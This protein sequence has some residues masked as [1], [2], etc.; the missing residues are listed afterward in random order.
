M[1][2]A[3]KLRRFAVLALV[4]GLVAQAVVTPAVATSTTGASSPDCDTS[5]GDLLLDLLGSGYSGSLNYYDDTECITEDQQQNISHADWYENAHLSQDNIDAF[6]TSETNFVEF[7]RSHVRTKVKA[8]LVE[9]IKNNESLATAKDEINQ[10]IDEF[11]V[12]AQERVIKNHNTTVLN[13]YYITNASDSTS[14]EDDSSDVHYYRDLGRVNSSYVKDEPG[15]GQYEVGSGG[16]FEVGQ[17]FQDLTL[18]TDEVT[19]VDGTTRNVTNLTADYDGNTAKVAFNPW[20]TSDFQGESDA[21]FVLDPGLDT[22]PSN[23]SE[24]NSSY[25]YWEKPYVRLWNT[26]EDSH[27]RVQNNSMTYAEGVYSEYNSSDFDGLEILNANDLVTQFNTDRNTTGYYGWAA[28]AFGTTNID[29]DVN[30]SFTIEYDPVDTQYYENGT[31]KTNTTEPRNLSGT[32]F[33][34]WAPAKTNGSFVANETYNTSNADGPVYFAVQRNNSSEVVALNGEFT[35]TELMNAKTHADLNETDLAPEL[36]QQTYNVSLTKEEIT[37]IIEYRN[38]ATD[39][40]DNGGGG[41][42]GGGFD[43]GSLGIPLLIGGGVAILLLAG[44]GGAAAGS[45]LP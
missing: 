17:N 35:I 14:T 42:R 3:S 15:P 21:I 8:E 32:L 31:L 26:I 20:D 36:Q 27:D 39:T 5:E 22:I 29:G 28:A 44:G 10:T 16:S 18:R 7:S 19:L 40:F 43:F 38:N 1:R 33:T 9:S 41:G 25:M 4:I 6:I 45:R 13:A 30:T 34:N 37:Y 11:Y 23:P 2:G 12:Q 24:A